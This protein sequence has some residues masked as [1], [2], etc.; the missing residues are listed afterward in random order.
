[1]LNLGNVTLKKLV[2]DIKITV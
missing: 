2:W 1:M